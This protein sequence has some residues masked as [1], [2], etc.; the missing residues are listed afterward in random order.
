MYDAV[1]VEAVPPTGIRSL[2]SRVYGKAFN[3][4]SIPP[5]ADVD[6]GDAS[7]RSSILS[8]EWPDILWLI[9]GAI[10]VDGVS[11][12]AELCALAAGMNIL[13]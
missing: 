4:G 3:P 10:G 6:T 11:T 12:A 2:A 13:R 7:T 9:G 1:H 8:G 5:G